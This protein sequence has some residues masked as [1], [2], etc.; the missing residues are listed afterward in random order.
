MYPRYIVKFNDTDFVR[1]GNSVIYEHIEGR[2]YIPKYEMNGYDGSLRKFEFIYINRVK[3]RY[4]HIVE[5]YEN[6]DYFVFD[7]DE[8]F[9]EEF[10]TELLF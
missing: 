5:D 9:M 10:F 2:D 1:A 7:T 4:N 3:K 6:Q 8:E